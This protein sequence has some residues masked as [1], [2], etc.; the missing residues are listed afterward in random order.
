MTESLPMSD[1]IPLTEV[2]GAKLYCGDAL[3][4]LRSLPSNSID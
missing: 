2:P 4:V 1:A 3:D